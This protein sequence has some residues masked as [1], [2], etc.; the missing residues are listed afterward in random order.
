MIINETTDASEK[1]AF[2]T[3]RC[4]D[5]TCHDGWAQFHDADRHP[6]HRRQE[7]VRIRGSEL[8]LYRQ[9]CC[10]EDGHQHDGGGEERGY[11]DED[12]QQTTAQ[13]VHENHAQ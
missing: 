11:A 10:L 2:A 12:D 13:C 7:G 5:D 4:D 3:A 6:D 1:A 8:V 9:A